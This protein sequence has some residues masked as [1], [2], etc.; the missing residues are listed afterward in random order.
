MIPIGKQ[1]AM[2]IAAAME[3]AMKEKVTV[4]T[5]LNAL[6]LWSV[7]LTT[8]LGE[9]EMTAVCSQ[10]KTDIFRLLASS[11]GACLPSSDCR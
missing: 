8:A 11:T 7:E 3:Y 5:T 10:V 1:V 9:T 2:M 4:T 6:D